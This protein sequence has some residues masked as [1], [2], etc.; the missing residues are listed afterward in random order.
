[1]LLLIT[2]L[3]L[4]ARSQG[5]EEG[6]APGGALGWTVQAELE[7]FLVRQPP[8]REDF[9]VSTNEDGLRTES[10]RLCPKGSRR[11]MTF[12][13]LILAGTPRGRPSGR[14]GRGT[15]GADWEVSRS[16]RLQLQQARRLAESA[17]EAYSVDGVVW[18]PSGDVRAEQS[19]RC[20]AGETTPPWWTQSAA[21]LIWSATS[22]VSSSLRPIPFPAP[23]ALP[24]GEMTRCR[25]SGRE[26]LARVVKSAG[27]GC[28]GG[29][30]A[31]PE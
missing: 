21:G 30:G 15:L 5:P 26:N 13:D 22:P 11:L 4:F 24:Q 9:L 16:A 2:A 7:D 29:G 10:G 28:L 20:C 19:D 23:E 6:F 14:L 25:C 8:P 31:A 18:L 27:P 17:I 3:E 1:M 12:G